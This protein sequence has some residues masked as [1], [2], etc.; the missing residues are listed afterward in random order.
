MPTVR[1]ARELNTIDL[2][3]AEV[4]EAQTVA[5]KFKDVRPQDLRVKL[6]TK[7]G[8]AVQ[9]PAGLV[10]LFQIVLKLASSGEPISLGQPPRMLT[11]VEAAKM[12]GMSRPTLIK[13]ANER[14]IAS[15]KVG[16]HTRF[17]RESVLKFADD[18]QNER[19]NDFDAFRNLE[20]TLGVVD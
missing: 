15:T 16:T 4:S 9:L 12:L 1:A 18:L 5:L 2:S 13:L 17:F 10:R 3:P 6:E 7:D 11:S 19:K 8:L 20:D 14:K